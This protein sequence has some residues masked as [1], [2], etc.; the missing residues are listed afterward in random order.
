MKMTRLEILYH[1]SIFRLSKIVSSFLK[2]VDCVIVEN[3]VVICGK[4]RSSKYF[5]YQTEEY[6][7]L[8]TSGDLAPVLISEVSVIARCP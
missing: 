5:C 8:D 3:Q 6:V 1:C 2:R 7:I 4:V